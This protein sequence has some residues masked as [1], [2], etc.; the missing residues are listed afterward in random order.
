VV[1]EGT[2]EHLYALGGEYRALYDLQFRDQEARDVIAEEVADEQPDETTPVEG[3][4]G[5]TAM[6]MAPA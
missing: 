6:K 4:E 3:S 5:N 1:E 2:H